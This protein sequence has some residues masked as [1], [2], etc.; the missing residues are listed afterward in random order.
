QASRD[1]STDPMSIAALTNPTPAPTSS[2]S[3]SRTRPRKYQ[4]PECSGWFSNLSTH[5]ATHLSYSSRPHS[6]RECGRGFSRPNDL[7][8][9]QKVHQGDYPFSCPFFSTEPRCHPSGGFSRCD[10]YKNHLKAMHFDYPAG[11][12][13]KDRAGAAGKCKGCLEEFATAD[14][15]VANHVEAGKC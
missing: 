10:T 14:D 7:L 6:C 1:S 9:H 12:K 5:R 2:P 15:W 11:T 13:K 8:R 4:C 3:D